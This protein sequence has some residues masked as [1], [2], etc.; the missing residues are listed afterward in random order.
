MFLKVLG[1]LLLAACPWLPI[2]R[3][4]A[5]AD[6]G[7]PELVG[8]YSIRKAAQ[9]HVIGE[10]WMEDEVG[11][12]LRTAVRRAAPPMARLAAYVCGAL[13]VVFSFA[14]KT[15]AM[16]TCVFVWLLGVAASVLA[17]YVSL[18]DLGR[19]GTDWWGRGR[20]QLDV[21]LSAWAWS[22]AVGGAVA[23]FAASL[24]DRRRV[25][26]ESPESVFE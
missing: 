13:L 1:T 15:R 12:P 17:L 25:S 6:W 20:W 14:R 26:P 2:L 16:R 23:H 9:P 11:G 18:D 22:A 19:S 5:T 24:A 7:S 10:S 8:Y 21:G 3:A 4:R